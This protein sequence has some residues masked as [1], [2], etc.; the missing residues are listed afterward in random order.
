MAVFSAKPQDLIP[1]SC[2]IIMD[3]KRKAKEPGAIESSFKM[4]IRKDDFALFHP[5]GLEQ[6][7]PIAKTTIVRRDDRCARRN[8][9]P[10]KIDV[11]GHRCPR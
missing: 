8:E 11:G 3:R 5:D 2:G 4:I 9:F 1:Q 10:V 6:A 7:I